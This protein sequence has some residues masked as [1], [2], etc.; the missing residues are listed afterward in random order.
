MRDFGRNGSFM[1]IR[2]LAQALKAY[3]AS[4]GK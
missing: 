2:E 3:R 1:V 4:G